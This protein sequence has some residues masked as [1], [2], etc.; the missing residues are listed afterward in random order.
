MVC[1]APNQPAPSNTDESVAATARKNKIPQSTHARR[2]IT[3]EDLEAWSGRLPKSR[4][5]GTENSEE[6]IAAMLAYRE[7]HTPEETER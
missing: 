3:D 7:S 1:Q 4:R 6:I 5:H 2:V